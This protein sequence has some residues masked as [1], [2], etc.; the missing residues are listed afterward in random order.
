[1]LSGRPEA[2]DGFA[3]QQR[4]DVRPNSAPVVRERA[5]LDA[6]LPGLQ[7]VIAQ[8]GY[9][10]GIACRCALVSR[11]GSPA[12]PASFTARVPR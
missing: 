10:D 9:C 7:I 4:H 11:I 5:G 6:P 12:R 1:M 3:A 8:L 2:G